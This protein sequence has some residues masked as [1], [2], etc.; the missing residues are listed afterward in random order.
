MFSSHFSQR[1]C[2]SFVCSVLEKQYATAALK[3]WKTLSLKSSP[4]S[5]H[6]FLEKSR[7][8]QW[9]RQP[10]RQRTHTTFSRTQIW[11]HHCWRKG[12]EWCFSFTWLLGYGVAWVLWDGLFSLT[13]R[14]EVK[15]NEE[16]KQNIWTN[17]RKNNCDPATE[18]EGGCRN[19]QGAVRLSKGLETVVSSGYKV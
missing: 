13:S 14:M 5:A 2:V 17:N 19:S 7:H 9:R 6:I 10:C 12:I 11:K 4:H 15:K 8:D 1:S 18:D 3:L 16:E